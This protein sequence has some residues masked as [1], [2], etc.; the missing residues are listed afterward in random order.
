MQSQHRILVLLFFIYSRRN[1]VFLVNDQPFKR[2]YFVRRPKSSSL[3]CGIYNNCFNRD[4]EE[5]DFDAN[6]DAHSQVIFAP[7]ATL[8]FPI[9]FSNNTSLIPLYS[10]ESD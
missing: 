5:L 6:T 3:G 10:V 1:D 7:L 8:S 2:P 9:L 4:L